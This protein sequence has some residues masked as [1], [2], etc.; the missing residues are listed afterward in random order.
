MTWQEACQ[1]SEEDAA[2]RFYSCQCVPHCSGVS[3]IR[4][5]NGNAERLHRGCFD[6][7][8]EEEIEG[9]DDWEPFLSKWLLS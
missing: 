4:H 6:H 1:V 7:A 8:R 9:Y 2:V 3:F 5:R